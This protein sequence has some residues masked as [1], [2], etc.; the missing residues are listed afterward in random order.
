L[1]VY[2]VDND[3]VMKLSAY[4]LFW[5]TTKALGAQD[6]DIRVLPTASPFFRR[7]RQLADQ[8]PQEMRDRAIQVVDKCSKVTV[9]PTD[10]EYLSL[11]GINNIDPGEALLVAG[12]QA[13]RDFYL[14][15]ADKKFLKALAA[16]GLQSI[17]QRLDHRVLC[18]EQL[19]LLL[20]KQ[21]N[22]FDKIARRISAAVRCEVSVSTAFSAGKQTDQQKAIAYLETVVTDL[23][24]QTG[25]LLAL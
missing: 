25:N 21:T 17:L 7:D 18:L 2:F 23:R 8:Y 16:S 5:E 20:L 24:Q 1:Q 12:T 19:I 9:S 22:D 6:Q 11:L 13:E 14:L 15:T 4:Q 10:A 3:I